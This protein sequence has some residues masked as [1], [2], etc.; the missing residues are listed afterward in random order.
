[1]EG[2]QEAMNKIK[3]ILHFVW[4]RLWILTI[5]GLLVWAGWT[6]GS[7]PAQSPQPPPVK[8]IQSWTITDPDGRIWKAVKDE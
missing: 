5:V 4:D 8:Q 1:M 7:I 6:L 2:M 3:R